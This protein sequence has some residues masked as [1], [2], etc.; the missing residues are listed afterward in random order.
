MMS[1]SYEEAWLSAIQLVNELSEKVRRRERK[2]KKAIYLLLLQDD[3]DPLENVFLQLLSLLYL[4][5][6]WERQE[7]GETVLN[8]RGTEKE[9]YFIFNPLGSH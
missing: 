3:A 6:I 7:G 5:L 2:R 4:E 8:V 1:S 9:K